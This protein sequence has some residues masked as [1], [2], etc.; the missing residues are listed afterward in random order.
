M[1]SNKTIIG[2]LLLLIL[3]ITD[4]QVFA[5]R[6]HHG[7]KRKEARTEIRNYIHNNVLPVML[8]LR[9]RLETKLNDSEKSTIAASKVALKTLHTECKTLRKQMQECRKAQKP[10][11]E[12]LQL[13][14]MALREKR[15]AALE[16]VKAIAEAQKANIEELLAEVSAQKETWK[17]DL[18]AIMDKYREGSKGHGDKKEGCDKDKDSACKGGE[19]DCT[20]A[21]RG[22]HVARILRPVGFLLL[23]ANIMGEETPNKNNSGFNTQV[24]PN[25]SS[26]SNKITFELAESGHVQI[27]LLNKNGLVLKNVLNEKRPSGPNTIEVDN[28]IL[29][30]DVYYYRISTPKGSETKRFIIDK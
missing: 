19:E 2:I 25:P 9:E 8:P 20:K 27:D 12:D 21:N 17:A 4:G 29:N 23:D 18:K 15:Q 22:G 3:F 7:K 13:K 28:S 26:I 1:K 14:M 6:K 10:I 24:F 5:Q 11:P 16:P 30:N